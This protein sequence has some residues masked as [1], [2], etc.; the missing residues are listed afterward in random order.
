MQ[1]K[2]LLIHINKMHGIGVQQFALM[3]CNA[4]KV[5]QKE[6]KVFHIRFVATSGGGWCA[7]IEGSPKSSKDLQRGPKRV[8]WRDLGRCSKGACGE[9]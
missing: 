6:S 1:N 2:K 4:R 7:R 8:H 9:I 3:R 5:L